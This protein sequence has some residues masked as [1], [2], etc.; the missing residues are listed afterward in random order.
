MATSPLPSAGDARRFLEEHFGREVESIEW[1]GDGAWSR[2]F[3]FTDQ[4]R[5]LVIRF[6]RFV[7]DFAKD[8]R[9]ASFR[10]A[11]LPVPELMEIGRAFGGHFAISSRARGESLES[12]SP[13]GWR[14]V[15][16]SLFA[17]LDAARAIDLSQT[18]G[19]GGWDAQGNAPYPTWRDFLLAVDTDTSEQRTAGW[20]QR[21]I[22]SPVG[23]EVFRSGHARLAALV[24]AASDAR[25]LVHGDLINRNVLVASDRIRAVF[26]WGCSFY[27][28][29]L[30]DIAWLE[31]W[32]PWHEGIAALDIR[33]EALRHYAT[34]GLDVPDLEPRLLACMIHIGLDH[35]AY[36]AYIG[37]VEDLVAVTKRLVPFLDEP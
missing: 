18:S 22:A 20:R 35:L 1:I 5:E 36:N 13:S 16:P 32:S 31:F 17:T 21:L 26:D 29:F 34:I 4:G 27:G 23:D 33:D 11:E 14:G 12:L 19:Y 37:N 8:L 9:A 2:C 30:Y 3:G 15:L 7:E 25:S 10:S 24:D 28:D 6:G